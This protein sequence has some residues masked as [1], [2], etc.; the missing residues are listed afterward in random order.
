MLIR[1]KKNHKIKLIK[2]I[3]MTGLI[4]VLGVYLIVD[5]NNTSALVSD[6]DFNQV[7]QSNKNDS[8]IRANLSV[9]EYL[10]SVI[11]DVMDLDYK[12]SEDFSVEVID[13]DV[14]FKR[15]TVCIDNSLTSYMT[16]GRMLTDTYRFF[17]KISKD[18]ETMSLKK[19]SLIYEMNIYDSEG[20]KNMQPVHVL[21]MNTNK[22]KL[23]YWDNYFNEDLIKQADQYFLHKNF[24]NIYNYWKILFGV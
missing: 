19:I 9:N 8:V 15:V 10:E 18:S 17:E 3:M 11:I 16:V 1:R 4:I 23:I 20:N 21:L 5:N 13:W 22:L 2:H 12:R 14:G 6:D 7:F 24:S